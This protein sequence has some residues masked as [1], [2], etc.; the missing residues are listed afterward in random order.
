MSSSSNRSSTVALFVYRSSKN[1]QAIARS[2]P[3]Q[4]NLYIFSDGW[5][6]ARDKGDVKAARALLLHLFKNRLNTYFIWRDSNLGLRGNIVS[7][8]DKV[9]SQEQY[10]ICI[11]DDCVPLSPFFDFINSN[12]S[13]IFP[14]GEAGAVGGANFSIANSRKPLSSIRTKRFNSWGWAT[15][16]DV[17]QSFRAQNPNVDLPSKS[18]IIFRTFLPSPLITFEYIWMTRRPQKISSWAI[19]FDFYLR[20]HGFYVLRPTRNLI[21]ESGE[22]HLSTHNNRRSRKDSDLTPSELRIRPGRQLDKIR[23]ASPLFETLEYLGKLR[24][25]LL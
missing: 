21:E 1:L 15:S 13:S 6:D 14:M 22:G 5:K 23:R 24:H 8:I 7:G 10:L 12:M 11:E 19:A 4:S 2:I 20:E 16:R 9:I 17:W 3:E 18:K 25:F